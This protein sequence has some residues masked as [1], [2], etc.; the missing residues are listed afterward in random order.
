M[1][2]QLPVFQPHLLV[3]ACPSICIRL[4]QLCQGFLPFQV[5]GAL[6]EGPSPAASWFPS[7]LSHSWAR[8]GD[9]PG[10]TSGAQPNAAG[11]KPTPHLLGFRGDWVPTPHPG[12]SRKREGRGPPALCF[13]VHLVPAAIHGPRPLSEKSMA[14]AGAPH[15]VPLTAPG[16]RMGK[17][18]GDR[19]GKG[20]T[21]GRRILATQKGV[22]HAL[23]GGEGAV[24]TGHT[25]GIWGRAAGAP[26]LG[27][28]SGGSTVPDVQSCHMFPTGG[29]H[30][31]LEGSSSWAHGQEVT[32]DAHRDA[33]NRQSGLACGKA[34]VLAQE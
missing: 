13:W 14:S 26:Q 28:D 6:G 27:G 24:E 12:E 32:P 20:A 17:V 29:W 23:Y 8:P 30:S 16:T 11:P 25:E 4:C 33:R 10:A 3:L 2:V 18:S 1:P 9:A 31:G 15:A 22:R 19:G 7:H 5:L 21:S 34:P